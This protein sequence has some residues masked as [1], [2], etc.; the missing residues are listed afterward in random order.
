MSALVYEDIIQRLEETDPAKRLTITPL[1]NRERQVGAASVDLRLGSEFLETPRQST[2]YLDPF[3]TEDD[4]E[5]EVVED[6]RSYVPLGNTFVLHPGQFV[7]GATLEFLVFPGDITGQVLSRSSWGRVGLLVA[8]AVAVH[9]GFRGV[10]TLELVNAGSLP[11]VLRPGLRVAQLQMWKSDRPT[12]KLYS[13]KYDAPLGP[14]SNKLV[15]EA[16]E[17]TILNQVTQEMNPGRA[18]L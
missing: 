10:L 11:I 3:K 16:A 9:P 15:A 1:L 5:A 4:E 7:L 12:K 2:P 14:Q 13:G 8:T 6:R 18:E 17:R